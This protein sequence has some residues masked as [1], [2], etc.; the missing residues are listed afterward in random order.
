MDAT[1]QPPTQQDK[2]SREVVEGEAQ[3]ERRHFY[4]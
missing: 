3:I 4:S 2:V 1:A